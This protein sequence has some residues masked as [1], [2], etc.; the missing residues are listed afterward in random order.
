MNIE[1]GRYYSGTLAGHVRHR[2]VALL[3]GAKRILYINVKSGTQRVCTLEQ[4][5]KWAKEDVT[6]SYIGE[7]GVGK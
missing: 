5:E 1:K 2:Y 4:F 6:D 3:T 7:E